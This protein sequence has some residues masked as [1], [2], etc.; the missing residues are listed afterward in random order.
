MLYTTRHIAAMYNVTGE[1]IRQWT[2]EFQEYLSPTAQPGK[3]RN[4]LYSIEDM[5]VLSLVS[6]LKKQ[7]KV[8]ADIHL[9]LRSGQRGRAPELPPEEMQVI[10]SG[11]RE[12]QASLEAERL[13]YAMVLLKEELKQAETKLA[14]MQGLKEENAKLQAKLEF[15]EREL[16][17]TKQQLQ[18]LNAQLIERVEQLSQQVGREYAKGFIDALE[19][20]GDIPPAKPDK[21]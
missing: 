16:E 20:R 6:E 13:Q 15:S 8:Y 9:N 18:Q 2:Y 3:N 21:T 11:E 17:E 19:R 5:E 14:Q 12:K 1:T 7:G 10:T 4:R